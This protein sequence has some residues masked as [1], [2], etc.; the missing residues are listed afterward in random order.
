[1]AGPNYRTV[2]E[3]LF[4]RHSPRW[5]PTLAGD[6]R[7]TSIS[8][9]LTKIRTCTTTGELSGFSGPPEEA[10]TGFLPWFRH[11]HQRHPG[12]TIICGHWAALG[13]HIEPSLIAI[14][15]GCIWGRQLTAIRLDDRQ[16]FQV[17]GVKMDRRDSA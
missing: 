6:E 16:V 9:V 8:R 1:L 5:D 14:D 17:D 12:T 15:T 4:H 11:S 13:L 3:A 10:P 2:L 7:L